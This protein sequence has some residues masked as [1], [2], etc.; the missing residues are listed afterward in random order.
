MQ[1]D[2]VSGG[3]PTYYNYHKLSGKRPKHSKKLKTKKK[4][5]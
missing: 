5:K 2:R 3:G 4:E 1:N